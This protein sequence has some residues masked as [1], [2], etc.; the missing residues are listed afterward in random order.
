MPWLEYRTQLQFELRKIEPSIKLVSKNGW[1]WKC[2]GKI[3]GALQI[4]SE[5]DFLDTYATTIGPIQ[6]YPS[7][8]PI[9]VVKQVAI[10]ETQHTLQCRWFGL[11]WS[12]WLGLIPMAICYLLLPVPILG[13]YG[14]YKME[15]QAEMAVWKKQLEE[16]KMPDD[17]YNLAEYFA[18]LL[19]SSKYGWALPYRIV[20][21]GCK[22]AASKVIKQFNK[23]VS[24]LVR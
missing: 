1:F 9:E 4:M 8:W 18:K 3:L 24:T 19:N 10:H 14:R 12:P 2:I 23:E 22:N 16:G 11:G 5:Y 7:N 20:S 13:A 17:I 15:V 21:Y 6:A